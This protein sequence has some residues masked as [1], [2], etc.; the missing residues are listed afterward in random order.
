MSALLDR[1][2][3]IQPLIKN[4]TTNNDEDMT[5]TEDIDDDDIDNGTTKSL[6]SL[7][8]CNEE[9][10]CIK[11]NGDMDVLE[12]LKEVDDGTDKDIRI[13]RSF[14]YFFHNAKRN[15]AACVAHFQP[16]D[17]HPI[18]ARIMAVEQKK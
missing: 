2:E 11:Y 16:S 14:F 13:G 10:Y 15:N 6:P 9:E 3:K 1:E 12:G 4:H 7:Y 8:S 5:T 17:I 18:F